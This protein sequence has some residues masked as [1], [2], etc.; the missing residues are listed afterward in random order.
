[1]DKKP[2][3]D[4]PDSLNNDEATVLWVIGMVITSIFNGNIFFWIILTYIWWNYIN[5]HNRG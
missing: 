3:Y 2:H 5:R 4:H 1:M